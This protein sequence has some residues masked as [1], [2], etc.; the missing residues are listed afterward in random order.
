[1][2]EAD[3]FRIGSAALV[4]PKA[5]ISYS[6]TS[7]GHQEQVRLWAERL[8]NDG[9]EV[10]VDVFDLK[11]GH[12]KYFFMERMVVDPEITHVLV[13]SDRAYAEKADARKAGVGTESQIISSEI[14]AKVDQSK[15]IP[16]VCEF[17]DDSD[18]CLPVFLK[19][20]IWIDFSS[21]EAA[22][23][24]WEK[25]VR[26]LYGKPLNQKPSIG[27]PPAYITADAS[28]PASPAIGKFATFKQ[29]L[30]SNSR[31]LNLYRQEFLSSCLEFANTITADIDPG[32]AASG[33]K[34]VEYC[35]LLRNVRNQI[36]D[37]VLIE[38]TTSAS[39]EFADSLLKLLE[40]LLE[41]KA[42]RSLTSNWSELRFEA[43]AIFV[44][45]TFLYVVAALLKRNSYSILYDVFT[46]HYLRPKSER[47]SGGNF[48][49][50]GCF[51][52]YS[53]R[54][55]STLAPV[56]QKLYSPTGELLKRQADRADLPFQSIIEADLL[57][58]LSAFLSSD[59]R[60]FAQTLYYDSQGDFP[61]FVRATQ[62]RH[63]LKLA[64]VVGISDADALREK[65][66]AGY[67]RLG[68]NQLPGFALLSRSL[69][70]CMNM[71]KLDSLR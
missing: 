45:E 13:F 59:V 70:E 35:G 63:F 27:K 18:P 32:S 39:Q 46:S 19:S 8:L 21:Q 26:L 5:F 33:E 55:Q 9:I 49:N 17:L 20:R 54:L 25:L 57:A 7:P 48:D 34:I 2:Q 40:D 51:A 61:F 37:W 58:M 30:L 66:R 15:F 62:H 6:W 28:I 52:A 60:W 22:N 67:D 64:M 68:V 10:I 24:N 47:F 43:Q 56:G 4:P 69:W 44:Y 11:E 23:E 38:S 53:E 50:F 29:A 12:D 42:R 36:V 3:A 16:I 65:A 14:Y 31:G 71:N 1:M 41:L